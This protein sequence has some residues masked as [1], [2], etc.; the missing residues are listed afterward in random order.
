MAD[1]NRFSALADALPEVC[2]QV[3]RK[4]ALDAQGNIQ[5]QIQSNDQIDTGFMF[6]SVYTQTDEGST[7]KGGEKA[8]P[9][10]EQP[11]DKMTAHVAVAASYG[12]PQ[13]YGTRFLPAR[14]FFEPGMERAR[15]GMDAAMELIEQKWNEIAG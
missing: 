12:A 2:S 11:E 3:V 15:Q 14:P 6:N 7:Y 1:I 8:L 13:N 9:E 4:T 5:A 10:T